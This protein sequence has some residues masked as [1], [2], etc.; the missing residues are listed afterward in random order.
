MKVKVEIDEGDH[1][2]IAQLVCGA[3]DIQGDEDEN[4]YKMMS[5]INFSAVASEEWEAD[6]TDY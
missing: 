2:R 1:F 3:F 6:E 5:L 4:V